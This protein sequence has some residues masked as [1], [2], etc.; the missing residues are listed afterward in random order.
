MFI[1]THVHLN[2]KQLESHLEEVIQDAFL[3]QVTT[4]IV[5]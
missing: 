2:N 5:V 4:M 3:K 1:D